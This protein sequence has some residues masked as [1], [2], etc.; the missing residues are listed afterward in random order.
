RH[1]TLSSPSISYAM[2]LG[3]AAALDAVLPAE[4]G[5]P[6]ED[7]LPPGPAPWL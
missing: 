3:G 7:T 1:R 4:P 5:A 2:P 6:P